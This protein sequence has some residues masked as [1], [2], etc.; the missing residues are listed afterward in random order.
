MELIS[1]LL[2]PVIYLLNFLL[3]FLLWLFKEEAVPAILFFGLIVSIIMRPLQVRLSVIEK[4]ASQKIQFINKKYELKSVG[5]TNEEKFRLKEKLY[6]KYSHSPFAAL[7]QASSF[8]LLIPILLSVVL[9]FDKHSMFDPATLFGRPISEPDG[10]LFGFNLLPIMMFLLTFFDSII[11][12][13]K[14]SLAKRN[15]II[16]SLFLFFIIYNLPSALILFWIMMNFISMLFY[17]FQNDK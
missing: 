5:M 15:F 7:K 17:Y 4:K 6:K 8:I 11:R 14:D 3:D 1:I 10:L 2:S 13:S 16:I 12:H 9:V